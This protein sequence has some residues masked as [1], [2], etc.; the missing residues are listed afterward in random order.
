MSF[1]FV[2]VQSGIEVDLVRFYVSHSSPLGETNERD[3]LSHKA[4]SDKKKHRIVSKR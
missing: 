2:K 4:A 1:K 3:G